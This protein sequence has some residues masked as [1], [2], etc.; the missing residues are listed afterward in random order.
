VHY[1]IN[2]DV[3]KTENTAKSMVEKSGSLSRWLLNREFSENALDYGCGK[4]RYTK[5]LAERSNV[6]G[7]VD[8]KIQ[9]EREQL[10]DGSYT[11]VKKYVS[12][13]WPRC[14][15]YELKTFFD[16][17]NDKYDFVLCAN[18]LSAI[19]CALIRELSL[20]SLHNCLS[21]NGRMLVVNLHTNSYF[22]E[23]LGRESTIKHLDGWIAKSKK[24]SAYYGILTKDYTIGLLEDCG[25]FPIEAWVHGQSNYVLV[26]KG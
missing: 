23:V 24:G 8:S 10:I 17:I 19:P 22:R 12:T 14:K 1:K 2:G 3:I 9:L 21:D 18:V 5:Y 13:R 20:K 6:I 11:T 16:N 7:I 15:V 4:L 26:G 25:F